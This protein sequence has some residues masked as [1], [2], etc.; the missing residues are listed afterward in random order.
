MAYL[1]AGVRLLSNKKEAVEYQ[2]RDVLGTIHSP[3]VL[4]NEL[5]KL[6]SREA[7]QFLLDEAL[8]LLPADS[9]AP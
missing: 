2:P 8:K 4:V 9:S 3:Q 5:A 1:A 6:A 7:L